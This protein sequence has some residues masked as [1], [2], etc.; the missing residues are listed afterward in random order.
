MLYI[1]TTP[2]QIKVRKLRRGEKFVE[3]RVDYLH[4]K[5]AESKR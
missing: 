3:F 2:E 4:E 5:T 1:G